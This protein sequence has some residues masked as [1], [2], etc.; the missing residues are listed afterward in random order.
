MDLKELRDKI[1]QM[2][3]AKSALEFKDFLSLS[4]RA[5]I[6]YYEEELNSLND[7]LSKQ[8]YYYIEERLIGRDDHVS[9]LEIHL[10]HSTV[11]HAFVSEE[12]AENTIKKMRDYE[13]EK[14]G[15]PLYNRVVKKHISNT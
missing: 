14:Y 1:F 6:D 4:D 15:K 10:W 12:E 11:P 3:G 7:Q 9:Y 8:E 5:D 13:I 2:E